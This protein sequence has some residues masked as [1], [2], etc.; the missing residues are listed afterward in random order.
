MIKLGHLE[1]FVKD[2][3]ASQH[4]YCDILGFEL[5]TVQADSFVWVQNE[6]L[7][8]LLRPG[9]PHQAPNYQHANMGLILY[10]DNVS[11]TSSLLQKSGVQIRGSDGDPNCLTF[12]DPD[13]HWFQLVNRCLKLT[14]P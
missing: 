4:F 5:V 11:V 7:E 9:A 6:H 13:G 3:L 10:T 2:P 12:T 1:L 8:I 14:H